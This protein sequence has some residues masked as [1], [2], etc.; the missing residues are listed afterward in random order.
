MKK[1]PVLS[2]IFVVLLSVVL[3]SSAVSCQLYIELKKD[4]SEGWNLLQ[5]KEFQTALTAFEMEIKENRKMV[6][7]N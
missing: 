1:K 2:F 5:K 3:F 7:R 4:K 6:M